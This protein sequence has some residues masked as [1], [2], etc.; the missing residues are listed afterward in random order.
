M[1]QVVKVVENKVVDIN[2]VSN[3][4]YYGFKLWDGSS[5]QIVGDDFLGNDNCYQAK[6]FTG[7]TVGNP[8]T[9]RYSSLKNCIDSILSSKND[10]FEFDT[11]RELFKWAAST[12][13]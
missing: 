6:F 5:G 11:Y 12:T 8:Y 9:L 7:S 1:K 13:L 10:V 4:K 2:S 3:D